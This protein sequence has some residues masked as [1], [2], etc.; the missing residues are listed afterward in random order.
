MPLPRAKLFRVSFRT[1]TFNTHSPPT[2]VIC[3]NAAHYGATPEPGEH[4]TKDIWDRDDAIEVVKTTFRL[5]AENA[6]LD[7]TELADEREILLSGIVNAF[8]SQVRRLDRSVDRLI[9]KRQDLERPRT[10]PRSTP[11]N[12]NCAPS[13]PKTP[14]TGATPPWPCVMRWPNRTAATGDAW[15][16]DA[17]ATSRRPA[18]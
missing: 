9:P 8:D 15:V 11:A 1:D 5:N 3:D 14:G 4:D 18:S 2:A 12:S 13:A 7:G 17:A 16:C 10:A 6:A